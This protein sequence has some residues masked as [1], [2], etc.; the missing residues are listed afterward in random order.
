MNIYFLFIKYR[1]LPYNKDAVVCSI[2]RFVVWINLSL[3]SLNEASRH[4]KALRT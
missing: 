2:V 3:C 1:L 4:D